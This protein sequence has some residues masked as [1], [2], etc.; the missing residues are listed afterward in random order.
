MGLTLLM[1]AIYQAGSTTIC[2]TAAPRHLD[3]HVWAFLATASVDEP[4]EPR[5]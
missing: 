4:G 2:T 5:A 1:N 3:Q